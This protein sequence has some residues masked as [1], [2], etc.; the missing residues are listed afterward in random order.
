MSRGRARSGTAGRSPTTCAGSSPSGSGRC[1]WAPPGRFLDGGHPLDFAALLDAQRGAGD[2]GRRRRP[3][4]GVPDGR[5]ADPADRAPA[6]AAPRRR[7]RRAA[8][9]AP[10]RDRGSPPAAAPAAARHRRRPGRARRRDVRRP[11]G[12]GPRL[13]RGPGHRRADPRQAHP[14]RHQEHRR[15]D[16]PPAPRRRRPRR[17]RR[18]HEPDR[19][20]V[21]LPGH[22]AA[23]RGRRARRRDGLPAAG[24]DARRHR[25]RG[26]RP[27]A[28]ASPEPVIARRSA[29]CG[30]DCQ[31]AAVHAGPDARRAARR[32]HRPA[33]HPVGRAGRAGAPDRLGHARAPARPSAADLRAMA[34]RLRDCALSHAADAAVAARGPGDQHPGSAPPRSPSTSPPRCAR[35]SPTAAWACAARRTA[36]PGPAVPVGAGPGRA[37]H[38]PAATAGTP[39]GTRAASEWE[40][41]YGQPVPGRDC[42]AQLAAV[43]RWHA[44]DQRDPAQVAAVAWGTRQ[45]TAIEQAVGTR[46]TADD[47]EQ[48]L[49]DALSAFRALRWPRTYLRPATPAAGN[50]A[51]P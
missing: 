41:A 44:R 29:T 33:D 25:P 21:R 32:H 17:R 28:A 8:A 9:A 37:P 7:P 19:R 10:D 12:R 4:Q 42:T 27:A 47:W 15:Q 1:G 51:A 2:R 5:G 36:V 46:A 13:R 45:H 38:R 40:R 50:P 48:H 22:P 26:R 39:G 14:R 49:T 23:R 24:P 30:P 18:D 34:G 31:A 20:P 3:R 43:R 6:A 11:A 35:P 16:R